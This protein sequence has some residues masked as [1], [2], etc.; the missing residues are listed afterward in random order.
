MLLQPLGKLS[1]P[2][3][4][5]ALRAVRTMPAAAGP[6]FKTTGGETNWK[7]AETGK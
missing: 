3:K 7:R 2:V 4:V 1:K 5:S 6:L